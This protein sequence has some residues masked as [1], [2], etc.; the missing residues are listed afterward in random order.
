MPDNKSIFLRPFVVL[1]LV[2]AL[3][4][5]LAAASG[6]DTAPKKE[7]SPQNICPLPNK[8]KNSAADKSKPCDR[9]CC[10]MEKMASC[11]SFCFDMKTAAEIK[12]VRETCKKH[13]SAD[14]KIVCADAENTRATALLMCQKLCAVKK[15][16]EKYG[17]EI[18]KGAAP[19]N[20]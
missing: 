1:S 3:A 4:I 11:D 16:L 6:K 2:I 8:N 13:S 7:A 10:P 18:Q 20:N 15:L 14:I 12:V 9:C 19:N 17:V 5:P